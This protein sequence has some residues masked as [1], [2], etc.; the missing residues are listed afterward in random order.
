M[1]VL[2]ELF[3][4]RREPCQG[5]RAAHPASPGGDGGQADGDAPE[6]DVLVLCVRGGGELGASGQEVEDGAAA[7]G[8]SAGSLLL[9]QMTSSLLDDFFSFG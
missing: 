4:Q 5:Q 3:Q 9:Y 7:G 1:Q 8:K 6:E 2:D